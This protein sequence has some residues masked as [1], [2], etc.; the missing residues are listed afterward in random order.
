MHV[1]EKLTCKLQQRL[2][3][4]L[5]IECLYEAHETCS[6]NHQKHVLHVNDIVVISNNKKK[7]FDQLV[8]K[9]EE[10][11]EKFIKQI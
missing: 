1:E 7:N 10:I 3:N 11:S 5:T 2:Q 8:M 6:T 9:K 4:A